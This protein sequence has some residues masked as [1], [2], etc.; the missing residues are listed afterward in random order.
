MIIQSVIPY[1][2]DGNVGD[3][4]RDKGGDNYGDN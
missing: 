3:Y 2:G 1:G 4:I